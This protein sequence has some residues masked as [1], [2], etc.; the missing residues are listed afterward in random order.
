MEKKPVP[1]VS[2]NSNMQSEGLWSGPNPAPTEYFLEK[3]MPTCSE[4]RAG[5]ISLLRGVEHFNSEVFPAKQT[6]FAALADGQSPNAL[7]IACA[8]SRINPSLITQ[9]E[10]G[11]LFILRNICNL[12]PAYGDML[13]GVLSAVEYAVAGPGVSAIIACGYSGRSD[14]RR[15]GNERRSRG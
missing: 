12:V 13:G 5:L 9:T 7:F 2:F 3:P 11:D 10:P 15:G 6:L 1:C 4:A 8:D 14:V